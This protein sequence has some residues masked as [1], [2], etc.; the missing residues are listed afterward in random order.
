MSA[1]IRAPSGTVT[2][3][4]TDIEGSSRLWEEHPAEMRELVAQHDMRFRVAIE[5]NDGYVVKATGDGFHAAF[6]RAADAVKAAERLQAATADLPTLK[7]RIGINTGEVQERDGDY[8]GPPVNR[9]ARLMS[10]A[11][12]GQVLI[13]GVTA[14][15]VPGLTLRNLGEH[16]LRDLGSPTLVW[17]LGTGEFPPL[18]TLDDLPGNLPVQR[19]SFVGRVE[20]VKQLGALIE[21]ERLV[22]L[23]GPGGV[24]KS[25]LA[26]QLA[27]EVAPAFK[28][29]AWFA[30]LAS[31]AEGSLVAGAVLEAVGVSQRQ[32]EPA[33]D[34]LCAW[35]RARDALLVIDNCEHLSAEV[36]GVVDRVADASTT[37]RMI[38]TSQQSLGVRGERLWT[39]APLSGAG[40]VLADSV[41]LFVDRARMA[42]A[43]FSLSADNEAA[44]I[45]ICTRLDHVPLAIELAAARMRGMAPAD[46]ARRLDQRLRLLASS[47]RLVAGRHRTLD[48]AMRWSYDLL[49]E[50]QRRVFDRLSVFA[51]PFTIEAAE[52]IVEGEGVEGWEILDRVLALVDKSLVVAEETSAGARYRL[53]ETMRHFGSANLVDSGVHDLYRDRHA[54]YYADYVLSRRPQLHGVGDI[55][56][57]AEIQREL[58]N[59]RVALRQAAD[60]VS[61]SRFD[62][63]YSALFTLWHMSARVPEGAAWAAEFL[64]RPCAD[65]RERIV[66][67]GFAATIANENDIAVGEALANAAEDLAASCD[68]GPPLVAIAVVALVAMMRGETD[69]AIA[70]VERALALA[71]DEPDLFVRIQGLSTSFSVLAVCGAI[72]RLEGLLREWSPLVEQLGS[73]FL[74]MQ[75]SNSTAPII[76]LTD[77][78]RAGEFLSR[79]YE[80]NDEMSYIAGNSTNAMFLAF[81]ELRSGNTVAAAR[82]AREALKL[83]IENTPSFVAQT[84][85]AIVATVKRHSLPDAAVILG[86]LQAHRRRKHQAGTWGEI[87]TEARYEASL[88]R[89]LGDQFDDAYAKGL[90]L[91]EAQMIAYAFAQLDAIT[92]I[93]DQAEAGGNR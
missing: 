46:I 20:E 5:A 75:I 87:E 58:E 34:T 8:F 26:L 59:I 14:D 86:A 63:L 70:K 3:L 13:A 89:G 37:L 71:A 17:Q 54:D 72:D 68:A 82:W 81:H 45:E 7:V 80:L 44:V 92:Q 10:A 30:S 67:L 35:S 12:G 27:A 48:A 51:G 60:D 18:Q 29:G 49:D 76:H 41:E 40:G 19:T 78:D 32:G 47:D 62:R 38:V 25:R 42:R 79:V 16:R 61:S 4:F 64:G 23:T 24:G 65:P 15:L 2:F 22:T 57:R 11:H 36:A 28:D 56:A 33:I 69:A 88:R 84:T 52:A 77:P 73:R 1:V 83:S 85:N 66:A 74:Q 93:S 55:P 39:V 6:G 31:L 21:T 50:T 90:A 43:D 53:L 9:A 91:D